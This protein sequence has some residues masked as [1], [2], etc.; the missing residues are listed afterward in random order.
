M[1]TIF[2]RFSITFLAISLG[3]LCISAMTYMGE[4][5]SGPIDDLVTDLGSGITNI[6]NTLILQQ[7]EETRSDALKWLDSYSEH[8]ERF[9]KPDRIFLG[10]YDNETD[11]SFESIVELERKLHTTFPLL[12]MYVAWG[13]KPE[14]QFPA[15]K[16]KAICDLGSIPV[17]T[18]EPWL[19]SFESEKYPHL[20]VMEQRDVN[21][22]VSISK[23]DYDT[24]INK[25][26]KDLKKISKPV[27]IRLGHE[28]NDPYRYPWGPQ[29]NKPEDFIAAWKHVVDIFRA[30]KTE[31]AIWVWSPHPA[32]GH[33]SEYYP[34]D[35]YVDWIG[36]GVL[37]YGTV[38][39]WS[40]WWSFDDIFANFYNLNKVYKKPVMV[41]E[42]GSLKVGGN[43]AEWYDKALVNM[44]VRY[45]LVKAV[46]FYHCS[47]DR[48]TTN[49]SLSWYIKNDSLVTT[50]INKDIAAWGKNK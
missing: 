47:D 33:Y 35:T 18:W 28:M 27:F 1:K 19:T 2:F 46:L 31:N 48:T 17:I 15:S 16:V 22:L 4:A 50:V 49:K 45:P 43:R 44:P 20:S 29:N 13:S 14:H 34:G 6:E 26:A 37:N 24:Y 5:S 36:T 3:V 21:G 23:G 12:H 32:Y 25:W 39:T 30:N 10:A 8:P 9:D 41:T 11:K 7:R 42:L 40:Q 38:A